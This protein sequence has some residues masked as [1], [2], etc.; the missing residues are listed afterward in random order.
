MGPL[1][2]CSSSS[3]RN[4]KKAEL[5]A[6]AV[7]GAAEAGTVTGRLSRRST[8]TLRNYYKHTGNMLDLIVKVDQLHEQAAFPHTQSVIMIS[9]GRSFVHA[10]ICSH[11]SIFCRKAPVWKTGMNILPLCPRRSGRPI[12]RNF[13]MG[14][15]KLAGAAFLLP[16]P[17]QPELSQQNAVFNKI[18]GNYPASSCFCFKASIPRRISSRAAA[19]RLG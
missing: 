13:G 17:G 16:Y 9:A 6:P 11:V 12:G 5:F 18:K 1:R 3:A 4:I 7:R 8:V 2:A 19:E 10:P 14:H 15:S